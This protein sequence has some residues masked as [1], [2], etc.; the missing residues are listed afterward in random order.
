LVRSKLKP[1][2]LQILDDI[3]KTLC[4]LADKL[5]ANMAAWLIAIRFQIKAGFKSI[6]GY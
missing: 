2:S 3:K 6:D 5:L 1:K 4:V